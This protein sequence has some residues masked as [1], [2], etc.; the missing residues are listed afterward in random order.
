MSSKTRRKYT[1]GSL[2]ACL[3]FTVPSYTRDLADLALIRRDTYGVPHIL[4]STEEAAAF[5]Q[6]YATA[7]DHF[8]D[9]A[10]LF[11]RARGEQAA[12]FGPQYREQDILIH[13][14]GVWETAKERFKDLPPLMQAILDA[15]AAGYNLYLSLQRNR[16]N[17]PDWAVPISGVDVLAH[18]RA[19]MVFEFALDL[20]PWKTATDRIP[21]FGSNMWAIGR[22]RSR[23]SHG[24]LLANPHVA[25]KPSQC[26]HELQL[27]VP[28]KI[29]ISGATLIGFPVV[30]IGFND[31]LGWAH[32]VN[33]HH[34]DTVYELKLNPANPREYLYDGHVLSMDAKTFSIGVK[35][36]GNVEI[37]SE[38][39]LWSHYGPVIR[40]KGD[41]AYAYKSANLSS[42]NFLTQY[43]LMA[44]ARSWNEFR[45]VL[46]MQELPMFNLGYTDRQ[47]NIFYLYNGRIPVLP[48]GYNWSC[49]V[50][51]NDSGTEWYAIHPILE[52]PQ[53]FNPRSGYIQNCNDAP[54]YVSGRVQIDRAKYPDYDGDQ[55]LGFRGQ[56]IIK[57]L[58][59][60]TRISLDDVKRYKY[61]EKLL[62]ADRLKP[63]LMALAKG[64]KLTSAD[65]AEAIDVLDRWDNTVSVKSRGAILFL[66][67]FE[68]YNRQTAS[69]YRVPWSPD[70]PWDTPSGIG[71]PKTAVSS[72]VSAS[73]WMKKTYSS[74]D[75]PWG[76]VH[77]LKRGDLNL[78]VGG[79][80]V[81]GMGSLRAI[82]YRQDPNNK[83]RWEAAGGDSY[84]LAVEFTDPPT[85][86]SVLAYSESSDPKSKHS[87]DQS[88]LFAKEGYKRVWI[89]EEDIK[90]HAERTYHPGE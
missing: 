77:H 8:R 20:T 66:R 24:I 40:V 4:A 44:K 80:S 25:W 79:A 32:T 31:D 29:N 54:W 45:A 43:N 15:Y 6:G 49:P 53:I 74:L 86:Y 83:T 5:A 48:K 89:T 78:P 68:E 26:F 47:G 85:A 35:N 11:L 64:R 76:E 65:L 38:T 67:W 33:Q 90:A 13:K 22:G 51:G 71:D 73:I 75:L 41:T 56:T 37:Q 72:L 1:I 3:I 81:E 21:G 12:V 70:R 2:L 30:T 59:A 10:R 28:G 18:C 58:E 57:L 63:D 61:S 23:S 34:S 69:P 84:V 60:S 14:L 17:A 88:T 82:A 19:V 16:G 9:L 42:V 50:P 52:F 39:A 7:E 27:T 87:N 46:N 36:G 55:K 62:L